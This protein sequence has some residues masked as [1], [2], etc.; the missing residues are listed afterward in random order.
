[1]KF[2][3]FS[4]KKNKKSIYLAVFTGGKE[5]RYKVKWG[6]FST[7][8]FSYSPRSNQHYY[9]NQERGWVKV[10]GPKEYY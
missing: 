10:K 8:D 4:F 7:Q 6:L 9:F 1:M 2:M 3:K 5:Y